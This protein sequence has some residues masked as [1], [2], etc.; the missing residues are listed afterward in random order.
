MLAAM[1][2][3]EA[4]GAIRRILVSCLLVA[5]S[6]VAQAQ[7][8][9]QIEIVDA[10]IY[11]ARVE[12]TVSAPHTAFGAEDHLSSV[13]LL[14]S[15][16]TISASAGM[17]FGFRFR[18]IGRGNGLMKLKMVVRVPHPGMSNPKTGE[19][20]KIEAHSAYPKIGEVSYSGY[21]FDE[22]WEIVPGT[23]IFEVWE[24]NR[25]LASQNFNIVHNPR[26]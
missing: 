3:D 16:T 10:G 4:M 2:G 15:T 11:E 1:M 7:V 22:D 23:W 8:A 18:V 19:I 13:K 12:K 6:S 24:G 26:V 25:K 20:T 17:R 9:E 5:F 21:T 14:Q